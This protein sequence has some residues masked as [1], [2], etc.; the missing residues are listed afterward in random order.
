MVLDHLEE[1]FLQTK[2][3]GVVQRKIFPLPLA[4]QLL[5]RLV[6]LGQNQLFELIKRDVIFAVELEIGED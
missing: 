1:I 3:Q 2:S 5:V 4:D 6:S